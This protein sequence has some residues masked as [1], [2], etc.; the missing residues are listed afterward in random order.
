MYALS[1]NMA[2][3]LPTALVVWAVV[4]RLMITRKR[5]K[6]PIGAAFVLF[7]AM[8]V[9]LGFFSIPNTIVLTLILAIILSISSCAILLRLSKKS[10]E[11]PP[12][13]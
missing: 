12:S 8:L 13:E 4:Y 6:A 2:Y 3:V 5:I 9:V 1:L 11:N 7:T 10:D